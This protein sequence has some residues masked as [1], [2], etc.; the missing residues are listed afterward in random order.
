MGLD[1]NL[2]RYNGKDEDGYM[3]TVSVGE[4]YDWD[5][6]RYVVRRKI[7]KEIKLKEVTGGRWN[8]VESISRPE[9]FNQAFKW[10]ETLEGKERE[11]IEKILR[12]LQSDSDLYLEFLY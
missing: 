5:D 6:T 9:D 3:N 12:I 8:D 4:E 2:V 7:L 10:A 1:I 11:Y